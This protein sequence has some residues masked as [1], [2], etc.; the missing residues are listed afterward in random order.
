MFVDHFYLL[1]K[2]IYFVE[3]TNS[4]YCMKKINIRQIVRNIF[5]LSND[6]HNLNNAY[7]I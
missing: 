7:T 4:D 2:E 5:I 3:S 1:Y 6:K